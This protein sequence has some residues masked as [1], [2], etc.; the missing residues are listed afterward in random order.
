MMVFSILLAASF[1]TIP[2]GVESVGPGGGGAFIEVR[3]SRH[4]ANRLYVGSDCGGF[5]RSDDFGRHYTLLDAGLGNVYVSGIA[6]H[7]TD[8]NVLLVATRG[9]LYKSTD[10][11]FHWRDLRP[12]VKPKP[13]ERDMFGFSWPFGFVAFCEKN[14]S[15]V[16]AVAG[17][18]VE[19]PGREVNANVW[20]SDDGG[21][22]WRMVVAE[23][24]PLRSEKKAFSFTPHTQ[25]LDELLL[26]TEHGVY[27]SEDAGEHW[28][29]QTT[30]LPTVTKMRIGCAARCAAKP[31]VVYLT[32]RQQEGPSVWDGVPY[33]SALYKSTD[34]GRTW[35]VIWSTPQSPDAG[36][37]PW[38][39][40]TL[41]KL[42]VD[43]TDPDVVL[44]TGCAF[45]QHSACLTRDGGK[46]WKSFAEAGGWLRFWGT[47]ARAVAI[48]AADPKRLVFSGDGHLFASEDCGTTWHQRYSEDCPDGFAHGTGLEIL[49]NRFV[50][51]DPKRR[52]RW[53]VG[54]W[55]VGLM[56]TVD[57]GHS[58]KRRTD[59]IDPNNANSCFALEYAPDGKTLW[60]TFGGWGGQYLGSVFARSTD[61]GLTWQPSTNGWVYSQTPSLVRVT[62]SR[63]YML[64]AASTTY[65]HDLLHCA[66]LQLSVDEGENWFHPSTNAFVRAS[67]VTSVAAQGGVLYV[68]TTKRKDHFGEV[69][70]SEDK[71]KTWTR[72]TPAG[73]KMAEVKSLVVRGDLI[74]AGAWTA[75]YATD[76]GGVFLSRD[77]GKTW[78]Q[79]ISLA[80]VDDVVV[81][82]TGV[83]AL[84]CPV[85]C[86][87]DPGLTG[88][89]V[90]VSYDF[91]ETWLHCVGKGVD[92]FEVTHLAF[93]PF[94]P[95][96][97]WC[98]T[99]GISVIVL[100][101][102]EVKRE[103]TSSRHL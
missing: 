61:N 15:R 48:S 20:R 67:E 56:E 53:F 7:P 14:P 50:K 47:G 68:G 30:G 41:P 40:W 19:G 65:G 64:A 86:W 10:G 95:R 33:E 2:C 3:P 93:D 77:G 101:L 36:K 37:C 73:L 69:W 71:G 83:L 100:T 85:V 58:L 72:L 88:E 82:S 60:A 28:V 84:A 13:P 70:K 35:R 38:V 34:G 29:R 18:H 99:G 39:V 57:N 32:M 17:G 79:T 54:Y 26:T 25:R 102:P 51:P 23:G 87:R 92:K 66:G 16:W 80:C 46:T 96:R 5:Y 103:K 31:D 97:L 90:L 24:D 76:G 11:G 44:T 55:D 12:G 74:V 91:G 21:E 78:K 94:D 42:S 89:G 59:G 49:C 43:P 45:F 62:E 52:G 1:Q 81:S 75:H 63:P 22:M 6:E 98:G 27:I 9:G 4:D 8:P